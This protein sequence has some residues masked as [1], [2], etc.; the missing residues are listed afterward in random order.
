MSF[1]IDLKRALAYG[2]REERRTQ[3]NAK[4]DVPV[5][6]SCRETCMDALSPA[7]MRAENGD[8]ICGRTCMA[9]CSRLPPYSRSS[10]AVVLLPP[11]VA[12]T[13]E[14]LVSS[15]LHHKCAAPPSVEILAYP[16]K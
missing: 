10:A 13:L 5:M 7:S 11:V 6:C 16:E 8:G 1:P 14:S 15:S 2:T 9:A 12:T 4:L 3:C